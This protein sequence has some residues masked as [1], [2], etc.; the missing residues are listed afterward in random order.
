MAAVVR[1]PQLR[2]G[3]VEIDETCFS[4]EEIG[5]RELAMPGKPRNRGGN[6]T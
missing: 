4:E 1:P 3:A 5:D 6:A 2:N